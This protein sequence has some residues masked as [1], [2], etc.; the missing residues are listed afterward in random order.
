MATSELVGRGRLDDDPG[1]EAAPAPG[2]AG[3]RWWGWVALGLVVLPLVVSAVYLRLWQDGYRAAGDMALTELQTRDV[4]HNWIELGPYS[5][6]GW[7]HP[8]PAL[9]YALAPLYR[10]LGS[11][12]INLSVAALAINA[13]AVAGMALLARRRGGVPLMLITLVALALTLR[14]LGPDHTRIAWNPWITVLSFGLL[15]F[16]TWALAC[17]E[18]WALPAA[19]VVAGA[20]AQTHVGYVALALPLVV[21]GVVWLVA[22]TPG[23]SR[24]RLLVPAVAALAAV[25]VMW[26][27][28]LLEQASN[29]PGNLRHS[30]SWFREGG[31]AG[32]GPN[33][34]TTGWNTVVT[35]QWSVP[36]E[37]A[38]G[39]REVAYT[40]ELASKYDPRPPVLLAAVAVA[41]WYLIRRRVPGAVQLVAVWAAATV[42][43]VVATART[44]GGLYAYRMDFTLVLGMVG[45]IIVAW[46]GWTALEAWRPSPTRLRPVLGAVALAAVGALAVVSSVAHVRAGEPA[47]HDAGMVRTLVPRVVDGLP[48][49]EGDVVVAGG[50]FGGVVYRSAVVLGL[51]KAGVD[52]YLPE[53]VTD[54]GRQRMFGGDDPVRARLVVAADLEVATFTD[55]GL[56]LIAYAGT[57]PLDE[58]MDRA[59]ATR[60]LEAARDQGDASDF[61]DGDEIREATIPDGS[62]VGVFLKEPV[63]GS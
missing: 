50:S 45:G 35:S 2:P 43:A 51:E 5:R 52:A 1:G 15:V 34:L 21:L 27:P 32:E 8:G 60:E 55:E 20:A 3:R 56:E 53:G 30:A 38:F 4:G 47:S 44:V 33:T 40:A 14:S 29:D 6:D 24:R 17:G 18:R 36:P 23:G 48:P 10:L 19:A 11:V 58:L 39:T 49:G 22:A 63:P 31:P 26:S 13:A 16:L 59:P 28:P 62:A 7:S 37:W 9:F 54:A 61:E 25:A 46:S 41:A 57:L 12:D 42:V